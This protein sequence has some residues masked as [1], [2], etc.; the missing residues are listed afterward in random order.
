[1]KSKAWNNAKVSAHHAIIPTEKSA[2]NISLNPFEKNVYFLI[3]RQYIAQFYPAYVFNQSRVEVLIAGGTF[4]ANA[5]TPIAQGWKVLFQRA[6]SKARNA[7]QK[8][9][10]GHSAEQ[11][12]TEQSLPKLTKG[13]QLHCSHG[14]LISRMTQAP[15]HFTDAS[16]LAAMTGIARYVSDSTIKKMLRETDGLG[17]EATRAGIIDLLFRRGYLE[18]K[19]KS[20]YA[21]AIGK[22]LINAL[23][24]AATLPDMTAHWE[25]TL[26]NISEK[27]SRY[28]DLIT[29]LTETLHGMIAQ[30]EQQSFAGLPKVPFKRKS[31]GKKRYTK[32][33]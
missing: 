10:S 18:R 28:D 25:A 29:P 6:K 27:T 9:D 33:Q 32:R 3:V 21:T 26:T 17:T 16:I 30:S 31:K 22:S 23:P 2:A 24:I 15:K 4:L 19:G 1:L 13:E 12:L 14:E 5:K 8:D 20:I 11:Q 7:A